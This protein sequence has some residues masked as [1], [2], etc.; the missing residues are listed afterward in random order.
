MNVTPPESFYVTISY[1]AKYNPKS[2]IH[3]QDEV[4]SKFPHIFNVK[5]RKWMGLLAGKPSVHSDWKFRVIV[6]IKSD[7]SRFTSRCP[8]SRYLQLLGWWIPPRQYHVRVE[9]KHCSTVISDSRIQIM[10]HL[11]LKF[12]EDTRERRR[13]NTW[14]RHKIQWEILS[15]SAEKTTIIKFENASHWI[16]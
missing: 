5:L 13:C 1:S 4:Q 7:L 8:S 15:L 11:T 14:W 3:I 12:Q 6:G 9:A 2:I 16:I 10:I